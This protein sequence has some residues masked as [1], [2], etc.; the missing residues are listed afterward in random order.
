MFKLAFMGFVSGCGTPW[1]LASF[2]SIGFPR[3]DDAYSD[4]ETDTIK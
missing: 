3:G 4:D 1:R 2:M